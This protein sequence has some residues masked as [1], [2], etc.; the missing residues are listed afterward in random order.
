M[1]LRSVLLLDCKMVLEVGQV[2]KLLVP[3]IRRSGD[4]LLLL[5]VLERSVNVRGREEESGCST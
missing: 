2:P 3:L 5:S 1:L 4:G